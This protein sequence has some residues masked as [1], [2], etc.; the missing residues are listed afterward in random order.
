MP[1]TGGPVLVLAGAEEAPL[2]DLAA[3][4]EAGG[5]LQL[6]RAR[7]MQPQAVT[8][9]LIDSNLRGRGGAGARG[10]RRRAG[11]RLRC[12]PGSTAPERGRFV[13]VRSGHG[14]VRPP[15]AR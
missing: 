10:R 11:A 7:V 9:E 15:G 5:Y 14:A 4:R 1:E 12:G 3:Y 2:R 8:Q 13:P 6:E